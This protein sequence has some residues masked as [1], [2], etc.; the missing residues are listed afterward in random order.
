MLSCVRKAM[1]K[2]LISNYIYNTLYQILIIFLPLLTTPY[3]AR[4]FGAEGI[5]SLSYVQS[6]S[7]YFILFGT[8]GTGL[9]GQREIAYYQNK[10]EA[11]SQVFLEIL[12]IR[13]LMLMVSIIVYVL[14]LRQVQELQFLF[15]LQ[16][17]E[18]IA[19]VFDISWY[20]QGMEDFRYIT[21]RNIAVKLIG[22]ICIFTFIRR[23]A[24]MWLYIVCLGM[25]EL[26]ANLSLWLALHK[27]MQLSNITKLHLKRHLFPIFMVFLPQIAMQIYTLFDRTMLGYLSTYAQTGYYDQTQK[28]IRLILIFITS[29][30]TVMMPRIA[31]IQ[32]EDKDDKILHYLYISYKFALLLAMPAIFLLLCIANRFIPWFLGPSYDAAISL[33]KWSTPL[34]LLI[35]LNNVTGMQYLISTRRQNAFTCTVVLG[36]VLNFIMNALLIPQF[37]AKGAILSSVCAEFLITAVQFYIVRKKIAFRKVFRECV[38]YG[39]CAG[40][41]FLC[42]IWINV[43]DIPIILYMVL[44]GVMASVSY[45]IALYISKDTL[46]GN[47]LHFL[48]QKLGRCKKE[49]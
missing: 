4:V 21:F 32:A 6:I 33:L 35:G 1:H 28:I 7:S 42:I 48:S 25:V 29:L 10:Q 9:Y 2:R 40:I 44:V 49:V 12:I 3:L 36:A 46:F 43:L 5:G 19:N 39:L 13:C 31:S 38:H 20:Y 37:A 18:I 34:L 26:I 45:G 24:D 15:L 41:M 30:G 23:K 47:M 8:L 16:M 17:I 14:Y 27:T 22:A 11:R